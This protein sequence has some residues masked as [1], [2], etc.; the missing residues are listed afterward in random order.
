MH[1]IG[2]LPPRLIPNEMNVKTFTFLYSEKGK[3][4][5]TYPGVKTAKELQ[6]IMEEAKRKKLAKVPDLGFARNVEINMKRTGKKGKI[7]AWDD[8]KREA[9]VEDME[10]GEISYGRKRER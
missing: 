1:D 8:I 10:T 7:L 2:D 6:K 5:K 4:I 3:T 9:V